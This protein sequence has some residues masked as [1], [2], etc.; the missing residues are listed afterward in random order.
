LGDNKREQRRYVSV[1]LAGW[2]RGA[3]IAEAAAIIFGVDGDR[4]FTAAMFSRCAFN[5]RAC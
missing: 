4:F 3:V 2:R 1:H 5:P